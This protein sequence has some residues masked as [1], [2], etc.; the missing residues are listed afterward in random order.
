MFYFSTNNSTNI[1]FTLLTLYCNYYILTNLLEFLNLI[2]A[3]HRSI[4]QT[5][6]ETFQD[7]HYLYNLTKEIK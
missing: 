6:I 3:D 1:L 4:R 5:L 7:F 2:E